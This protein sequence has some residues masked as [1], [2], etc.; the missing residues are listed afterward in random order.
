MN[1]LLV[2]DKPGGMTSR[3]VVN[4]AQ[5]WFPR[6]TKLGHTGTLDPLATGTLVLCVGAVTR[7]ADFVQAMGKGYA[8]RIRLGATSDTDDADGT[9]TAKGAAVPPTEEQ[10]RAAVAAFVGTIQ[11]LPPAYSALKVAGRRAHELARQGAEVKLAPRP[12]TVHSI[13]VTGYEWPHLDLTVECG[14]GTYIRSLAHADEHL[15]AEHRHHPTQRARHGLPLGEPPGGGRVE[16]QPRQV[17][18]RLARRPQLRP[19]LVRRR[20]Q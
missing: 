4:R 1:G 9:V 5:R 14:K 13:A 17:G 3:D 11:Q 18:R 12:V 7:L 10:V 16:R 15:P 19:H 6:G 8:T 2:I 20:V